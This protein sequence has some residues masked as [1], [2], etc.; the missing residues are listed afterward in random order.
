MKDFDVTALGE[1][2][3]D[4][5]ENGKSSQGN[6]LFEANPGGA[7]CNVL[8]M[9]SKL[10]HKTAFIGKVGKDFFGEQL[11]S[12]IT[13]VGIDPSYL[14]MDEEIHTTLAMVHTYPDGDRDFSFYRN[15]GADMMLTEKEVPEELIGNSKIFH[16][17]TL[18]M[19]HD[20]V[21]KATKKAIDVAKK[22]GAVISFDPNLRPPLWK[23][24]EDAK[25]Q[26]AFGFSQ[27]D[28]LKISDNEIQWFTGE[29]DY[30]EGIKKLRR[31]RKSV[32]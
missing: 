2:L 18:S 22:S 32:V 29:E 3:I 5:T 6:P 26:A 11:K 10:G 1:L 17:G 25:E 27:C 24:L 12:A 9:L 20:E 4:F 15:P 8:S 30:D 23:S 16:F 14:C 19:T 31:D 28:V 21:R 7:P 13:E